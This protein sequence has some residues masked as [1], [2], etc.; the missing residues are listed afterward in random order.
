MNAAVEPNESV[1]TSIY[2]NNIWAT[3]ELEIINKEHELWKIGINGKTELIMN[4]VSQVGPYDGY[5][6][7]ETVPGH[8][9]ILKTDGSL[10]DIFS[11]DP[12]IRGDYSPHAVEYRCLGQN[13]KDIPLTT[14]FAHK[15]IKDMNIK[16]V[17]KVY[18][19]SDS[20]FVIKEDNS[21][22]GWGDNSKGQMGNGLIYDEIKVW[23]IGSGDNH[24]VT[25]FLN[26]SKPVKIMD[27]VKELYVGRRSTCYEQEGIF[28]LKND[29]T[30]W[31]WGDSTI[32]EY[33]TELQK[34]V[35]G[36][37]EGKE[38]P[39]L[40]PDEFQ[41]IKYLVVGGCNNMGQGD[42]YSYIKINND[43]TIWAKGYLD[44]QLLPEFTQIPVDSILGLD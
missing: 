28:A 43:N 10:W 38:Y 21:L 8:H 39:R 9:G 3:L 40:A 27:N 17:K 23:R 30:V 2:V 37:D 35:K 16:D 36:L 6:R 32:V 41:N 33:D 29:G 25:P 12:V 31:V 1:G 34:I 19:G 44:Y 5:L 18:F 42:I 20:C 15:Q 24:V 14:T 26:V 11:V 4:D 22:W 7:G 13:L